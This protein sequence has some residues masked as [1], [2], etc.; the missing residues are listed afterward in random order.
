MV[1]GTFA[2][3]HQEHNAAELVRAGA[4]VR[5]ADGELTPASLTAA[6]RE[7]T[8]ERLLAMATASAALGRPDAA[9]AIVRVLEEVAAGDPVPAR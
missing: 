2:G 8:G 9:A 3:G 4:A 6:L 5:I 7:L 1:P